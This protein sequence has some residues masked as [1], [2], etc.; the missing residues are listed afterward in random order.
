M[1]NKGIIDNNKRKYQNSKMDDLNNCMQN[2]IHTVTRFET[3]YPPKLQNLLDPPAQLYW[4]GSLPKEERPSVAIVGARLCSNYGKNV[5]KEFAYALTK[6]GVQII[7]GMALGIDGA[8][9]EG[10]L[11]AGGKTYAVLGCGVDRCYPKDNVH[12]YRSI[13]QNGGIISEFSAGM[14]PLAA[15]FPQ[16]N[17][18]ISGLADII[19]VVEAKEK[20]GSLI[21]VDFA[22][23]QGRTVYA[24]PGRVHDP[25][26]EG[27][28]RLIAQ[29]AGIA[30]KP[31]LILEELHID[32]EKQQNKKRYKER[33]SKLGLATNLELVYSCLDLQPQN[34]E[35]ILGKVPFDLQELSGILLELQF[36]DLVEETTKNYYARR[37]IGFDNF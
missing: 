9:H 22:L 14:P 8:A 29:G 34:M 3:N 33:N 7:S 36:L 23:E 10:A 30:Y 2:E 31:E 35:T 13:P 18:I 24:V 11:E 20:S 19:L 5:A 28:H 6:A 26:S 25:L 4:K 1:E 32:T 27:C 37:N 12:L 16:R 17:R 21:T 15:N